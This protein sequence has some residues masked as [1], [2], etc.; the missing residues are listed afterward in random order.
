VRWGPEAPVLIQMTEYLA[1]DLA[2]ERWV[3]YR[4]GHS[5]CSAHECYKK[6]CLVRARDPREIHFPLGPSKDF[7]FSFDPEW[8]ALI[9]FYCPQCATLMETE[10]LPPGHPLTWDMQIDIKALRRKHN[11]NPPAPG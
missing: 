8:I 5:L 7:N 6:G 4:C 9:E 10:Y 1:I 2:T 11:F 3:C